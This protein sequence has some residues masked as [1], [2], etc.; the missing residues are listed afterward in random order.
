M[1][2]YGADTGAMDTAD[3]GLPPDL[4]VDADT[5]GWTLL[6]GDCDDTDDTAYAG[7]VWYA[8]SDGDGLTD[9]NDSCPNGVSGWTSSNSTDYDGDGCMDTADWV[10]SFVYNTTSSSYLDDTIVDIEVAANGDIV[11]MGYPLNPNLDYIK[12]IIGVPGDEVKILA[13]EVFVNGRAMDEP[14]VADLDETSYMQATVEPG[15]YFVL[16]D[17]RPHSSD[18]REFGLVHQDLLKGKVD[19]CLW[20]PTRVGLLD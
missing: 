7:L 1:Q 14:Y 5:D 15:H 3:P 16:G 17:N 19:L 10:S 18:S 13:G 11:V 6:A 8:D 2:V 12:R 4:D 20:P 9:P